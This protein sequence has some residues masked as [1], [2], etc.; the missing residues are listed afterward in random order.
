MR[1]FHV[2]AG[3]ALIVALG[4]IGVPWAAAVVGLCL[5][6]T[7]ALVLVRRSPA[8]MRRRSGPRFP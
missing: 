4:Y 7:T 6:A 1:A 5:F 8:P 3:L 2:F